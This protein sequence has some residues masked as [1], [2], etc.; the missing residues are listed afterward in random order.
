MYSLSGTVTFRAYYAKTRRATCAWFCQR[1]SQLSTFLIYHPFLS[2]LSSP[3]NFSSPF[4]SLPTLELPAHLVL[5]PPYSPL[6][7]F[8]FPSFFPIVRFLIP[9]PIYSFSSIP[10]SSH[11]LIALFRNSFSL[12]YPFLSATDHL[13]YLPIS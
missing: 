9:L 6:S 1:T 7:H 4:P 10:L 2:P 8:F 12:I 13:R 5:T 3:H 11:T